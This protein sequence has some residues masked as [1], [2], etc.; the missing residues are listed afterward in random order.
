MVLYIAS[1]MYL[2]LSEGTI[3]QHCYTNSI[4]E[5]SSYMYSGLYLYIPV[6]LSMD[7]IVCTLY[8]YIVMLL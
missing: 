5:L 8:M 6:N 1:Y 2:F 3:L 7:C 4:F